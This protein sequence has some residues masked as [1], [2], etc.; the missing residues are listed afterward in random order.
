M[1]VFVALALL[2]ALPYGIF[3]ILYKETVRQN[4]FYL[5]S[6]LEEG[7]VE[8]ISII[9]SLLQKDQLEN[10]VQIIPYQ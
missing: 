5:M 1:Q 4:C 7:L 10:K 9:Q 2:V 6:G 3:T 8:M